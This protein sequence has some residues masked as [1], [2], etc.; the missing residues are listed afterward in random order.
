MLFFLPQQS[1][2][3]YLEQ[4]RSPVIKLDKKTGNRDSIALENFYF[5]KI[6]DIKP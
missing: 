2:K 6:G 3:H 4:L 5:R 1:M